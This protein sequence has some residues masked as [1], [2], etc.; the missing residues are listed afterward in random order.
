MKTAPCTESFRR[1]WPTISAVTLCCVLLSGCGLAGTVVGI[2]QAV[3]DIRR[4]AVGDLNSDGRPYIAVS[5]DAN[6]V[7]IVFYQ[8]SDGGFQ[9]EFLAAGNGADHMAI[10]DLSGDGL[11]DFIVAYRI[12]PP[13]PC[14]P[15]NVC[16]PCGA[17]RR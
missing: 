7:V 13:I 11:D 5:N 10:G 12:R 2:Q 14:S 17:P 6:A 4:L 9:A 15:C 1:A 16:S 3:V 8:Q